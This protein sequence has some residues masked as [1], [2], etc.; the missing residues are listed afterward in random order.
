DEGK[1]WFEC[2][3]IPGNTK[4][5][6]DHI[7]NQKFYALNLREGKIYESTDGGKSFQ[8]K[9]L[10]LPQAANPASTGFGQGKLYVTPEREGNLW[11]TIADGLYNATDGENF[12]R[13]PLVEAVQ[14]FGFGKEAPGSSYPALYLVGVVQGVRGFYRPDNGA[15]T[16]IRINDNEHEFGQIMQITGDPK[17]Y[18][19]V[20]IGTFGRGAL[21]GDPVQ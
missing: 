9:E 3:G 8:P 10:K 17:K 7:N 6:A 12:V 16:W 15:K 2:Q 18:G 1:S 19:R 11:I 5:V 13:L 14:G 21:Y 20:Y 4:V